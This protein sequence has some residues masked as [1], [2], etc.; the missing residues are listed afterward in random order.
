[1]IVVK[2][3]YAASLLTL[4]TFLLRFFW[5]S[6]RNPPKIKKRSFL[7]GTVVSFL[8]YCIALAIHAAVAKNQRVGHFWDTLFPTV[9]HEAVGR[10]VSIV[11]PVII[12]VLAAAMLISYARLCKAKN[13]SDSEKDAKRMHRI[14]VAM[15][16]VGSALAM[17]N[18]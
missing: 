2:L 6:G 11:L 18:I 17:V 4:D 15:V 1:M 12:V 10:G 9:L 8:A 13:P 7:V 3:F 16:I 5:H 14:G